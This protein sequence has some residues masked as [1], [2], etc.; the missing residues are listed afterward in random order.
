MIDNEFYKLPQAGE[1]LFWP[2]TK[3]FYTFE[4]K[5][6]DKKIGNTIKIQVL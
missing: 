4:L 1:D 5:K 6:G 3:G 2:L